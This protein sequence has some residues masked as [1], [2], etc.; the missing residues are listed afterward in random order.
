MT[1]PTLKSESKRTQDIHRGNKELTHGPFTR[2][3][4]FFTTQQHSQ[5]DCLKQADLAKY[6]TP[7]NPS[8][9]V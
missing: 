5:Y 8:K 9:Y 3:S 1:L 2:N 7:Y 4:T 6:I